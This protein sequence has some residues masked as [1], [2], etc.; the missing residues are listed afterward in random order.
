M[1]GHC[2]GSLTS[3]GLAAPS[4][5]V[6][7]TAAQA[8]VPAVAALGH[9]Q[10]S[11]GLCPGARGPGPAGAGAEDSS[12]GQLLMPDLLPPGSAP[13]GRFYATNSLIP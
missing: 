10:S 3:P 2:P 8:Q 9:S 12:P 7:P 4:G 5:W 6:T 13:E 1:Q 11:V